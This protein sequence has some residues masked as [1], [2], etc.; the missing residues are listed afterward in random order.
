MLRCSLLVSVFTGFSDPSDSRSLGASD[1]DEW[2]AQAPCSIRPT[3]R[4][5]MAMW[6]GIN[7]SP[8]QLDTNVLVAEDDVNV[9]ADDEVAE[10]A[11]AR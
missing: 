3:A 5:G 6:R 11:I 7:F 9:N 10:H 2:A 4:T 1:K 8:S